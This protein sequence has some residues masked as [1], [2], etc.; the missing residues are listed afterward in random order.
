VRLSGQYRLRLW[1]VYQM[2]LANFNSNFV[3]VS[4]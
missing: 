4:L 2:G 1:A 3:V